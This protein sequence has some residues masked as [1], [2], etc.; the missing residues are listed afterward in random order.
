MITLI[1][2]KALT[3]TSAV[4]QASSVGEIVNLMAVDA[5]RMYDFLS[6]VHILWS[7]PLQICLAMYYL[8]N[9]FQYAAFAGLV[10]IILTLPINAFALGK[11]RGIQATENF[12]LFLTDMFIKDVHIFRLNK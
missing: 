12:H 2:R 10:A 1:Y 3:I 9:E 5:M 4:K 7:A 6:F 8:Y 11:N